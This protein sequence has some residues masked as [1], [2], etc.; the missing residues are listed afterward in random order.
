MNNRWWALALVVG[1]LLFL[2]AK[3]DAMDLLWWIRGGSS[4]GYC[5]CGWWDFGSCDCE[6]PMGGGDHTGEGSYGDD[7]TGGDT[8]GGDGT[9]YGR[10]GAHIIQG[11]DHE[12]Y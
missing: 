3:A 7:T 2:P 1:A 12:D 10:E 5:E 6:P 8:G 4:P 9:Q 11:D